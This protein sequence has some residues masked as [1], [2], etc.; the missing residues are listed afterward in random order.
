MFARLMTE[1][2]TL[3]RERNLTVKVSHDNAR[4]DGLHFS[5]AD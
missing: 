5:P 3:A 1:Q 4:R 2:L